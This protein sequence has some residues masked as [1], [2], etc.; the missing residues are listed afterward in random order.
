L[1]KCQIQRNIIC[2]LSGSPL[3]ISIVGK[4]TPKIVQIDK[5]APAMEK[6]K[7]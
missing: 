6:A 3:I 2:N 1:F 5:S 7:G 4:F